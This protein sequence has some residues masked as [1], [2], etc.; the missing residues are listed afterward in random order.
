MGGR[1][2]QVREQAGPPVGALRGMI[3]AAARVVVF[4]GAGISTESGIPDF[5]SPGGIWSQY[6]PIDFT[7]FLASEEARIEAWQRKFAIDPAIRA[8]EPNA[9]HRAVARLVETGTCAAVITQNIDGLHQRSG[10]ADARVIELHG[11]TTYAKCLECGA[12]SE[13]DDVRAEFER[14]GKAPVCEACGGFVKTATIS[15]GQPMPDAEMIRAEE[16]TLAADLFPRRR[17]LAGRL[18][19]RRLPD[20]RQAERR[21]PRDPQPGADR[22]RRRRRPRHQR[23]DRP[24]AGRRGRRELRGESGPPVRQPSINRP[25]P[26]KG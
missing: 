9:G 8:A 18:S 19:G 25:T 22:P 17:Q 10:V 2:K 3:E 4:T 14:T 13:I 23:R 16:E 21:P 24:D 6:R 20:A 11:N 26:V 1:G 5:R 12:R 15:F 7:E